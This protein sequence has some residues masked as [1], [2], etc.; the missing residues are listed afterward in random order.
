MLNRNYHQRLEDWR[1]RLQRTH[2]YGSSKMVV[3][4]ITK[5]TNLHS[6]TW[7]TFSNVYHLVLLELSRFPNVMLSVSGTMLASYPG[8]C[9]QH[10]SHETGSPSGLTPSG[11]IPVSCRPSFNNGFLTEFRFDAL[12]DDQTYR[13]FKKD[14]VLM[15]LNN[16]SLTTLTLRPNRYSLQSFPPTK[17]FFRSH[18]LPSLVNLSVYGWEHSI[19]DPDELILWGERNG[20]R[21]LRTL[22]IDVRVSLSFIG[23]APVLQR[24][25]LVAMNSVDLLHLQVIMSY[26]TMVDPEIFQQ[27][28]VTEF[29]LTTSQ[30]R[31]FKLLQRRPLRILPHILLLT[32]PNLRIMNIGIKST[33]TDDAR[34]LILMAP[35]FADIKDLRNSCPLIEQLDIDASL[36]QGW[37]GD[38]LHV[39]ARFEDLRK[40]QLWLH[41]TSPKTVKKS[42]TSKRYEAAFRYILAARAQLGLESE[43]FTVTF[44]IAHWQ[45]DGVH[46]R[47]GMER[48]KDYHCQKS[49][50]ETSVRPMPFS[51]PQKQITDRI[52]VLSNQQLDLLREKQWWKCHFASIWPDGSLRTRATA[53]L[54]AIDQE[55]QRREFEI[56]QGNPEGVDKMITLFDQWS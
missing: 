43:G 13:D 20:W 35:T 30:D 10:G 11:T 44:R 42:V 27:P 36:D 17:H 16:R 31:Y 3:R 39:L 29:T 23:S 49:Q 26:F 46:I 7:N 50:S 25:E 55:Y 52:Q 14:L 51:L 12:Y 47:K 37:P 41:F 18:K 33:L 6:L 54:K 28:S 56:A 21:R 38:I 19:F 15:M 34:P 5:L 45:H 53:D 48:Y 22:A 32:M 1:S 2:R 40:L 24:L 8:H 9:P 4:L